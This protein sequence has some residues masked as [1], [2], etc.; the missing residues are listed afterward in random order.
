MLTI[1]LMLALIIVSGW[2]D[3]RLNWPTANRS[4]YEELS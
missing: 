1:L 2:L 3:S 4:A